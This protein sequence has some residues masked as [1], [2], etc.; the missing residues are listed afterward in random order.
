MKSPYQD[1][2]EQIRKIAIDSIENRDYRAA[3]ECFDNLFPF[4]LKEVLF[5][6]RIIEEEQEKEKKQGLL[7]ELM[8]KMIE[9]RTIIN[10]QKKYGI[11]KTNFSI[12]CNKD[13][14]PEEF[15]LKLKEELG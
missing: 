6:S 10:L 15:Y 4:Y 5:Y 11:L 14:G 2:I 12:P 13:Y 7:E 9:W 3:D 1:E 8:I